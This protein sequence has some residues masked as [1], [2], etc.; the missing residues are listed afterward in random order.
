[1]PFLVPGLLRALVALA[2]TGDGAWIRTAR[3]PEPLVACYRQS[4]AAHIRQAIGSGHLRAAELDQ[5]L[6][7]HELSVQDVAAFGPAERVLAN[8]NTPEDYG[9]VQ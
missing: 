9:R 4:A 6:S 7:L 3:G 2:A 5:R 1:M 8:L